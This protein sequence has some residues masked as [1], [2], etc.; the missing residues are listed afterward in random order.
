MAFVTLPRH[1]VCNH[2]HTHTHTHTHIHTEKY[3]HD[4]WAC[5]GACPQI[6]GEHV[7]T[8]V[9]YLR[10]AQLEVSGVC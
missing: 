7:Q 6:M 5:L 4:L 10:A 2:T 3:L 9:Q 8:E 1:M